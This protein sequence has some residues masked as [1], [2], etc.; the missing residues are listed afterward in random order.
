[1]EIRFYSRLGACALI[2]NVIKMRGFDVILVIRDISLIVLIGCC[3]CLVKATA[4]KIFQN[5]ASH[6]RMFL[7]NIHLK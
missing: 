7:V 5:T 6:T 2:I 1:M 4:M 3:W